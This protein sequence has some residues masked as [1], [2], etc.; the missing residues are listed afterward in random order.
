M[1][2]RVHLINQLLHLVVQHARP[3]D[4]PI[5]SSR[6]TTPVPG[7]I[8][9]WNQ[10]KLHVLGDQVDGRGY[11]GRRAVD[12]KRRDVVGR[13]GVGLAT[14][15]IQHLANLFFRPL[16]GGP[17]G[18]RVFQHVAQPR[19]QVFPF[20]S[21][22]RVLHI[23]SHGGDG[24]RVVLLNNRHQTVRHSC[25]YDPLSSTCR[26]V[27]ECAIAAVVCAAMSDGLDC[28]ALAAGTAG[29]GEDA[30]GLAGS[31]FGSDSTGFAAAGLGAAG[32]T[33]GFEDVP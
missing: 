21:T 15:R 26:D 2:F 20:V 4:F 19:P 22:A 23:A 16:G 33:A 13:V 14:E 10:R 29:L 11:P 9:P 6:C 31:P 25:Q 24:G 28:S 18:D 30:A 12:Q 8:L 3:V 17:T 1:A 5:S 27:N 32:L 7:R